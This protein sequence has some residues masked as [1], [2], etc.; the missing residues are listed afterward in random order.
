MFC[1]HPTP[2]L[3]D[4][5]IP[6]NAMAMRSGLDESGRTGDAIGATGHEL[7]M[8]HEAQRVGMDTRGGKGRSGGYAEKKLSTNIDGEAGTSD[9]IAR[10][11]RPT[12]EIL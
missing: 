8:D 9:G 5:T 10:W 6:D 3:G 2:E 4:Y 12:R 1:G 11:I 7:P